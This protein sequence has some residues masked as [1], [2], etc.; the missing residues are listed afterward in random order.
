[1]NILYIAHYAGSKNHGMAFRLY[2]WAKEW[3]KSGRQV[4]IIAASHSHLRN[5]QPD[6]TESITE[7]T[8]D[9]IQ[10]SWIKTGKYD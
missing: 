2:Y 3:L 1:M 8:I 6:V 4:T 9:G 10:Y 5:V 7:E